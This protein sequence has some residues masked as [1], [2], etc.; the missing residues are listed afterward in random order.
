MMV[1]PAPLLGLASREQVRRGSGLLCRGAYQGE[2]KAEHIFIFVHEGGTGASSW[3]GVKGAG[4]ERS[5][6]DARGPE[7]WSSV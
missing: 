5:A 4:K 7:L 1:V 6:Q 3:T 2:K